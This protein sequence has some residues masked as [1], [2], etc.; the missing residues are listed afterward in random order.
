MTAPVSTGAFYPSF[1][2]STM[3]ILIWTLHPADSTGTKKLR[4]NATSQFCIFTRRSKAK[5]GKGG[6]G[7]DAYHERVAD[8]FQRFMSTN[9]VIVR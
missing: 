2:L 3:A 1:P 7:A 8:H 5:Q 6:E 4:L 9:V